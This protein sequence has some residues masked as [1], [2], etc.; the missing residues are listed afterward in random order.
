MIEIEKL[1][2][3]IEENEHFKEREPGIKHPD[4]PSYIKFKDGGDIE[5][6]TGA[7]VAIILSARSQS[8]T[9]VADHI[10]FVTNHETGLRWNHVYFNEKATHFDEPTF[11]KYDPELDSSDLLE[12]VE[13]YLDNGDPDEVSDVTS[14]IMSLIQERSSGREDA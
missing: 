2:E 4:Y 10:K 5:L 6:S 14:R 1:F 13:Y 11:L 9:F 3:V 12:G 7:G 8:I